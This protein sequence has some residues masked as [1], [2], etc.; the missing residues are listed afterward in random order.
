MITN[1]S[2][3]QIVVVVLIAV[4]AQQTRLQ[5]KEEYQYQYVS[6]RGIERKPNGIHPVLPILPIHRTT[7]FGGGTGRLVRTRLIHEEYDDDDND[8]IVRIWITRRNNF[9][10]V[11]EP[12]PDLIFMR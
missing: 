10:V 2:V 3:Q 5:Q 8:A 11:A 7:I 1:R 6:R 12:V 4:A 9:S